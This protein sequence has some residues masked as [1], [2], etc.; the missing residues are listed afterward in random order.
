MVFRTIDSQ[1]IQI[2]CLLKILPSRTAA[3]LGKGIAIVEMT[4]RIVV[5]VGSEPVLF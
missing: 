4:N 2:C 3:M 1:C 5:E